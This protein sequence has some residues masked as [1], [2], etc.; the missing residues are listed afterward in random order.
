MIEIVIND[1]FW[2]GISIFLQISMN[3]S[4]SKLGT[5]SINGSYLYYL[6]GYIVI[7]RFS[8]S[9]WILICFRS[10]T[11]KV[12][13]SVWLL[14]KVWSS[15]VLT[16]IFCC[17]AQEVLVLPTSYPVSLRAILIAFWFL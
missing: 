3:I 17:P 4:I 15:K 9:A 8:L 13:K 2:A 12:A 5:K 14:T 10:I 16:W 1:N 6:K 7:I 11:E